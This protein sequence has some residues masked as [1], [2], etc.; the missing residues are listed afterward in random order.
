MKVIVEILDWILTLAMGVIF[1]GGIVL[2]IL[3][4]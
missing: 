3:T 1:I 4:W 2:M